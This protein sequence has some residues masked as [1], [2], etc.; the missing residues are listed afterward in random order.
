MITLLTIIHVIVCI[1]LIMVILLQSG[2][3]AQLGAVFGSSQTIFGSAG[4]GGFL[5]KLTTWFA[6]IFMLTSLTLAYLHGHPRVSSVVDTPTKAP[7][8]VES[9]VPVTKNI[10]PAQ[11]PSKGKKVAPPSQAP[12]QKVPENLPMGK[13]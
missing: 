4:P 7:V 6:V 12:P 9:R 8:P 10:Q 1:V 13:E 11:R 3:G 5:A 2:K